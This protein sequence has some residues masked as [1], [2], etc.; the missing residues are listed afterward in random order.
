MARDGTIEA[1]EQKKNGKID[2]TNE[3]KWNE[4]KI[5]RM[6]NGIIHFAVVADV[7]VIVPLS[8]CLL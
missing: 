3:K 5:H 7:V 6:L 8:P 4:I 1:E 2:W